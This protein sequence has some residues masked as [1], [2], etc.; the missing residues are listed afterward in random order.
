MT[1]RRIQSPLAWKI[2][3]PFALLTALLVELG[4]PDSSVR[5]FFKGTRA[6]P[7]PGVFVVGALLGLLALSKLNYLVSFVFL[8]WAILWLRSEVR[9]WGRIALLASIAAVIAMPWV[10]YHGWVNDWETGKRV[11][12]YSEQVAAPQM[13]PSAQASPDSFPFRAS[14]ASTVG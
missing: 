8:G 9:H 5:R 14:A 7:T 4:W 10:V 12:D 6:R 11:A 2:V 3:L 13:K 1:I